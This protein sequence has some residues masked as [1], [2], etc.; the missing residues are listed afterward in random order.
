M[1]PHCC[2][3]PKISSN[4]TSSE[5]LKSFVR[6]SHEAKHNHENPLTES[7]DT[8]IQIEAIPNKIVT[9]YEHIRGTA[10]FLT[11]II[12]PQPYNNEFP[13]AVAVQRSHLIPPLLKC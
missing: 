9:I 1:I 8:F 3:C 13:T 4:P 10:L 12:L 2:C 11:T 5:M 7:P 6:S